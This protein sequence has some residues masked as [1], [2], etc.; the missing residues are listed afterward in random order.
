MKKLIF[1][2]LFLF[3]FTQAQAADKDSIKCLAKNIYFEARNQSLAGQIAVGQVTINRVL[4]KRYP[5]TIC[6][7]VKQNK[8]RKKHK[9]Q[10]SWYCDGKPD[11]IHDIDKFRE[12]VVLAKSLLKNSLIDITSGSTHYHSTKV[13]PFWINSKTKITQIDDHIFYRWEINE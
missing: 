4:D 6:G 8:S 1:L 2:V 9:C 3:S 13:K 7:V 11:V 5:N 10:F 12:I